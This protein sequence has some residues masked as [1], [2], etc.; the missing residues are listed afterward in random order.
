MAGLAGRAVPDLR[1]ESF[2]EVVL[3]C[4]YNHTR[5]GESVSLWTP[6]LKDLYEGRSGWVRVTDHDRLGAS[7][8]EDRAR[9][10]TD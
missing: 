2:P 3:L 8:A 6:V 9:Q 7:A 1:A 10:A 4:P 5:S